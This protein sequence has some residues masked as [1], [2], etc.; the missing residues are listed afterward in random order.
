[1]NKA[2]EIS[3]IKHH[4]KLLF[5]LQIRNILKSTKKSYYYSLNSLINKIN[6]KYI[7][8]KD[9]NLIKNL[10]HKLKNKV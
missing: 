9:E 7:Y 6:K 3:L 2:F 1:M 10:Y 4:K 8:N 5:I